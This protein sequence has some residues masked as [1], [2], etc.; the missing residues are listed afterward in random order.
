MQKNSSQKS[1]DFQKLKRGSQRRSQ[2]IVRRPCSAM[3]TCGDTGPIL[4]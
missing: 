4:M 2:Q 3:T 1:A